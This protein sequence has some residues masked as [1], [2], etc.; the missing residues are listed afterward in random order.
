MMGNQ[1]S[2]FVVV[3]VIFL[4][5]G[6]LI[7]RAT[8]GTTSAP[9]NEPVT[10]NPAVTEP[11]AVASGISDKQ[12]ALRLAM[13]KLWTDHAVWTREYIVAAV[14]GTPDAQAA[15]ARLLQNQVDIGNAIAPYY[16]QDVGNKLA[17]LLKQHILIAVDIINDAKAKDQIKF[18]ADAGKWDQNGKDIANFL[19]AANPN[20]WPQ[21]AMEDMMFKHL[22]TTAQELT[23]YLNK[24]YTAAAADFDAVYAHILDMADG[25]SQGIIK[26]FPDKF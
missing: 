7:G 10:Q 8:K 14:N 16:G 4:V 26:Q 18:Q 15:A 5:L 17:D 6:G 24:N 20:N 1:T 9:Q 12:L 13:R 23:D 19:S 3:A 22:A 25:L 21:Q 11:A 2:K